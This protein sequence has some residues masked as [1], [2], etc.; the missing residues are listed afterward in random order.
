MSATTCPQHRLLLIATLAVLPGAALADACA[1]LR[2]GWPPGTQA[3]EWTEAVH[4]FSS[5]PAL[6]LIIATALAIRFR[7]QWGGLAVTVFWSGLV[8]FVV[9]DRFGDDPAGLRET[10]IQEGCLGSPTLF[11]AAVTAICIATILYTAPNGRQTSK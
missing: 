10:A 4:H 8:A 1:T 11:I 3:T 5:I 6:A 7:S 9:W 2:P